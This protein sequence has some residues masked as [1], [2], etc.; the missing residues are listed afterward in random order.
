MRDIIAVVFD[1]V[2]RVIFSTRWLIV[3]YGAI[4]A[5]EY[6]DFSLA[7]IY[8]CYG[9]DSYK[10][11]YFA[12]AIESGYD[13]TDTFDRFGYVRYFDRDASLIGFS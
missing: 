2:D 11:F 8:D 1:G 3:F 6:A 13:M 12:E 4:D 9:I 5:D 7:D 10:V